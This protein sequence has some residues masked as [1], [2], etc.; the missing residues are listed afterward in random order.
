MID[1]SKYPIKHVK[2]STI[3][4]WEQ[5]YQFRRKTDVENMKNTLQKDSQ[6][7]PIILIEHANGELVILCGWTRFL[8]ANELGWEEIMAVMSMMPG[9]VPEDQRSDG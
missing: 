8:A 4:G 5:R 1:L 9:F 3:N 2:L 6:V 7:L